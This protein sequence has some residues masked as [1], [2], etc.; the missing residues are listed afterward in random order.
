MLAADFVLG[1]PS[2]R[3][4]L[5]N[6]PERSASIHDLPMLMD[7]VC[8]KT[9]RL[10]VADRE[11]HRVVGYPLDG[12]KTGAAADLV[13]GEQGSFT[14][15]SC[16]AQIGTTAESLCR[17]TSARGDEQ[18]NIWV[19]DHSTGRVLLFC[20]GAPGSASEVC[21]P[22]NTGDAVADLVLGKPDLT[23]GFSAASCESP[24]ASSL[25]QPYDVV[26]D[27]GRS[28]VIISDQNVSKN[29]GRVLLY[30]YPLANGMAA[31]KVI[32][33]PSG[34]FDDYEASKY[35]VCWGGPSDGQPCDYVEA[36]GVRAGT[37]PKTCVGG[38]KPHSECSSEADCSGGTCGCKSPGVCDFSRSLASVT[39][40]DALAIHPKVDILYAGKGPHVLEYRGPLESGMRAERVGGFTVPHNFHRGSTGYTECQWDRLGGGLAFDA[41]GNLYLPQGGAEDF[42]A[43]LV[44]ADPV[45]GKSVAAPRQRP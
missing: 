26:S 41:D 38:S 30:E 28:R 6:S 40:V 14:A 3:S 44:V 29:A 25:C 42:A 10:V 27:P 35:G 31:S 12:L 22:D 37:S 32:G 9:P 8:G 7:F 15:A 2:A 33:I 16:A 39:S 20:F 21:K 23:S 19:A 1:Q 43:V 13:L 11:N 17:P 4:F 34:R 18:G 45:A 36:M 24:T 5:A